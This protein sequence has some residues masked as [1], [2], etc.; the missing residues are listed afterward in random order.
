MEEGVTLP[1]CPLPVGRREGFLMIEPLPA[2]TG[3]LQP[4]CAMFYTNHIKKVLPTQQFRWENQTLRQKV[5]FLYYEEGKNE[6][7]FTETQWE[8]VQVH[9]EDVSNSELKT[10]QNQVARLQQDMKEFQLLWKPKPDTSYV[11]RVTPVLRNDS[12]PYTTASRPTS[13]PSKV[14]VPEGY[15]LVE[16]DGGTS[17]NIPAQG[18]GEG[19]GSFQ[20]DHGTIHR[21][22]FGRGHS[23]N[24]SEILTLA[25]ALEHLY[26]RGG[27]D[28]VKL[29]IRGDS[30]I[31]LKWATD[32]STPKAKTSECFKQAI[33]RL[34]LFNGF[35]G[36]IKTE[37]RGRRHSVKL[38]GH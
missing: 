13:T 4:S 12:R 17:C 1:T 19:Y 9:D 37:W 29:F 18:Y 5:H 11:D 25:A 35:F 15:T 31:A 32:K 34:R 14:E 24:A 2:K 30:Q 38:F 27:V 22:T 16:F 20:I 10:L 21:V 33:A 3:H 23:S 8:K 7:V 6:P 28:S 26:S 36:D